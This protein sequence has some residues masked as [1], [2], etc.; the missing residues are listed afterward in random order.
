[1]ENLIWLEKVK[2]EDVLPA[3]SEQ[4]VERVEVNG[5]PDVTWRSNGSNAQTS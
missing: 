4:I 1:M 5:M 2:R 3:Y